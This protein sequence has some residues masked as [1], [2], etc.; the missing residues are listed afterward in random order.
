MEIFLDLATIIFDASI[1]LGLHL[2][3]DAKSVFPKVVQ[4]DLQGSTGD[5]T[6]V[7]VGRNK[8]LGSA[9]IE[10]LEATPTNVVTDADLNP[11]PPDSAA[12]CCSTTPRSTRLK[13]ENGPARTVKCPHSYSTDVKW[14]HCH[15]FIRIILIISFLIIRIISSGEREFRWPTHLVLRP[16][17]DSPSI[18]YSIPFQEA[19]KAL[20]TPLGLQVSMSS[21]R[22]S[23]VSHGR[24]ILMVKRGRRLDLIRFRSDKR[25]AP[26]A[27]RSSAKTRPV[28]LRR[29]CER[30]CSTSPAEF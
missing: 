11:A 26:R 22:K 30:E 8:K 2:D 29:G 6:G 24:I 28:C 13:H 19:G 23:A 27:P 9:I 21:E 10:R 25:R 3:I 20:V 7:Y 14:K 18:R 4:V 17:S 5:S 16:S 1:D 15:H 12:F